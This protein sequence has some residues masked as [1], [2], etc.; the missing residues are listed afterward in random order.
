MHC[1]TKVKKLVLTNRI[2]KLLTIFR[3]WSYE[4]PLPYC[5]QT[6]LQSLLG[7]LCSHPHQWLFAHYQLAQPHFGSL[8]ALVLQ[9]KHKYQQIH[10]TNSRR[11]NQN[12]LLLIN[13]WKKVETHLAIHTVE[14]EA[15]ASAMAALVRLAGILFFLHKDWRSRLFKVVK[16]VDLFFNAKNWRWRDRK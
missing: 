11:L 5:H 1:F 3:D 7:S 14:R 8:I 13:K 15:R 2:Q 9:S 12:T 10:Q 6:S 16:S 4:S